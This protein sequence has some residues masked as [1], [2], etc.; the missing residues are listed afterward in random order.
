MTTRQ[1]SG[2][3]L[4]TLASV[5]GP[6]APP[7]PMP[8]CPA[9]CRE[10]IAAKTAAALAAE[11]PQDAPVPACHCRRLP[12]HAGLAS[13]EL[14]PAP[15]LPL[16][17]PRRSRRRAHRQVHCALHLRPSEHQAGHHTGAVWRA[18]EAPFGH[19]PPARRHQHA[20]A[21][22]PRNS[23]VAGKW[24]RG[25]RIMWQINGGLPGRAGLEGTHA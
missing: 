18:G 11:M 17:C 19:A 23:Q 10:P 8:G 13:V 14:I 3:C 9:A 6:A 2:R 7:A 5:R 21:G 25:R 15:A 4:G 24:L 1:R 22:R 16:A 20:A 12:C